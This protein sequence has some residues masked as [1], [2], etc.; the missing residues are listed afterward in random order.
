MSAWLVDSQAVLWFLGGHERL[1]ANA[2]T[3]MRSGENQLLIGAGSISE[4][5]MKAGIGKLRV[6]DEFLTEIEGRGFEELPITFAHAW[7]LRDLPVGDH[8]DPFDRILVAQALVEALP[9]I[10]NDADLDQYGIS[11]HW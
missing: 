6:P 11:R 3:I 7:R 2:L 10:S 5:A 1:S 4:L 9:V 8:K